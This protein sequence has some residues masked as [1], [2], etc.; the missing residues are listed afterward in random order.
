MPKY[1]AD[2]QFT[3]YVTIYVEAD[4]IEDAKLEAIQY[5]D[6]TEAVKNGGTVSDVD[7]NNVDVNDIVEVPVTPTSTPSESP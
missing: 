7:E 1:K 5:G 3:C 4:S 2:V 6:F